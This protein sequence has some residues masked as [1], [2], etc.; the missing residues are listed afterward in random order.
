MANSATNYRAALVTAKANLLSALSS[1]GPD[2]G[3]IGKSP[4][5]QQHVGLVA[6]IDKVIGSIDQ[7]NT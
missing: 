6:E 2:G 1:D 7:S 5:T 3:S 4:L